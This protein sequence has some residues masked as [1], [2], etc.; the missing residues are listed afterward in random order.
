MATLVIV[1]GGMES[2]SMAPHLAYTRRHQDGRHQVHGSMP[3]DGLFDAFH[4][5]H[6]GV[7]AENVA[8]KWQISREEQDKFA[9]GS[10]K[11]RGRAEG[12][13]VP[14]RNRSRGR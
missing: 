8:T 4:G 12:R 5:Y 7:T 13:Q 1:A 10:Q 14:G 11:G 3:K 2:M 9:V 6:M